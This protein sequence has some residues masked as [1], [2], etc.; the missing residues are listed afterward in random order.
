MPSS[1]AASAANREV[2]RRERGAEA[3]A[4]QCELEAPHRRVDRAEQAGLLDELARRRARRRCTGSRGPAL[5]AGDRRG[6]S[7]S[8]S[9]RCCCAS[10]SAR[11]PGSPRCTAPRPRRYASAERGA[12]GGI[13]DDDPAPTLRIAA[14][15]RLD[16]EPQALLDH[17]GLDRPA[18]VEALAHR[19]RRGEQMVDG[20]A[21]ERVTD[22]PGV[23]SIDAGDRY[24]GSSWPTDA[25]S[26]AKILWWGATQRCARCGSGHLFRHYFTMVDDCPRCGLHFEREHGLLRRRARDQHH[27][28]SVRCSRSCSSR[29]SS[30]TVPDVPV[31]ELLIVLVP[32]ARSRTDRLLPVLEDG[33]G[34]GRPRVPATARPERT[35]RLTR[36]ATPRAGTRP[37]SLH[38]GSWFPTCVDSR[39]KSVRRS[40]GSDAPPAASAA[41]EQLERGCRTRPRRPARRRARV[42]SMRDLVVQHDR[43]GRGSAGQIGASEEVHRRGAGSAGEVDA[44]GE[45]AVLER[46][47]RVAHDRVVLEVESRPAP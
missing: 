13:G 9:T 29:C 3:A 33:L 16:R 47:G 2:Q 36:R 34:R 32:I 35:H 17:L 46:P 24:V 26:R 18:E 31:V 5:R 44:Q 22:S 30:A 15:R 19:A 6:S 21:V 39:S 41:G 25:P 10:A 8:P 14:G 28:R 23:G 42:C 27:R 4:P 1:S 7:P 38:H 40:S 43:R 11:R 12:L 20:G 37:S 45:D